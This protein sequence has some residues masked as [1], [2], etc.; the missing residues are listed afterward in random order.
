MILS[1]ELP[2]LS[3]APHVHP[4][5]AQLGRNSGW[6]HFSQGHCISHATETSESKK[7]ILAWYTNADYHI[8]CNFNKEIDDLNSL[9]QLKSKT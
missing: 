5:T 6:L 4:C 2:T 9:K 8:L 3:C 7:K 1:Q